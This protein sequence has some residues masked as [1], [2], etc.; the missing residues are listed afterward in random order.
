MP[1]IGEKLLQCLLAAQILL[2]QRCHTELAAFL[3]SQA[4]LTAQSRLVVLYPHLQL[5]KS[6]FILKYIRCLACWCRSGLDRSSSSDNLF[7]A[8]DDA[9][10]NSDAEQTGMGEGSNSCCSISI[11]GFVTAHRGFLT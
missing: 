6:G 9:E 5:T 3:C 8:A 2:F 11:N 1:Q 7:P 4:C 10:D